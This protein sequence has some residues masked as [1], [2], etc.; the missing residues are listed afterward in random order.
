MAII[1][2]PQLFGWNEIEELGDLERLQLVLESLPDETL[3]KQLE[4]ERSK[5]R[6]DYPIRAVWNSLIAGIVFQHVS[7]ESLRRELKR[8]GQLRQICGFDVCRGAKAVPPSWAYSRFLRKLMKHHKQLEEI[9]MTLVSQLSELLPDFGRV[10]AIDGKAIKSLAKGK[11]EKSDKPEDGRRD[12]DADWGKKVYRGE[13]AD[14]SIWE[15]EVS[16]FGYKLHLMVDANYEL[17][18][19]YE[20]TSASKHELTEGKKVAKK[21]KGS[22]PE[23][24]DRCEYLT[25]DRGY[26]DGKWISELWDKEGIKPVI[27]IRNMWRTEETKLVG[28][29]PNVVYDHKG[30]VYCHCPV[31]DTIREM[32]YG[33]FEKD[34][35]TLKY[36]CPAKHYGIECKGAKECPLGSAVRIPLSE[37]RRVFTPLARSSYKWKT[38]YKKRTA[39]ERVNSR[40]DESFGFEKHF[41]RGLAKM[42]MRVSL[43]LSVMLALAVGRLH[44]K[45]TDNIRSLVKAA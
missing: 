9:F 37:D 42:K 4:E 5:G 31:T 35:N 16:W 11:G 12:L 18:V 28:D 20:V 29:Y 30:T 19:G 22:N 3:V 17:P 15:K 2:Q 10:L 27:D 13:R 33:G 36:R 39:V 8:N 1:P 44:Q 26:D 6:N 43:A 41:I 25:A 32:A 7:I 38:I 24:W 45:Q 40:L 23:V 21:V 14:G 34:R